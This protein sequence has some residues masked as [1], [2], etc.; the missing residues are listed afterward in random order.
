M[1]RDQDH[2]SQRASVRVR[3]ARRAKQISALLILG[4]L[5]AIGWIFWSLHREGR[6]DGRGGISSLLK[7]TRTVPRGGRYAGD[8]YI[9]S[10]TCGEC[11]PGEAALF[12]SSGH[13]RTMRMAAGFE[14]ADELAGRSADDPLLPGVRWT[15]QRKDDQFLVEREAEGAIRRFVIDYALGS[16]HHAVTFVTMLDLDEPRILEHRLTYYPK[17]RALRLTPG[18]DKGKDL[19]GATSDGVEY[20][21]AKARKCLGCHSTQLSNWGN[22]KLDP[23]T[24]IAAVTC[25]RCHG[26]GRAHVEATKHATPETDLSMPM[27]LGS[28]TVQSQFDL[29]GKCHR[30][31]A[32]VPPAQLVPDDPFLARFQPVGLSQSRCFKGSDGRLSCVTCHDPHARASSDPAHYE[33]ICM[34]CHR[35]TTDSPTSHDSNT[36]APPPASLCPVSPSSDCLPCHMPKIDSGQHVAFSDH[37][38]RVHRPRAER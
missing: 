27:G 32:R 19:P 18:H 17:D 37:W 11:H 36:P 15:F 25:E 35:A 10:A 4:A 23:P 21:G 22:A 29:C 28:W 30:H 31:P 14:L 2:Q 9:G 7:I 16:G 34:N 20:D 3:P 33:Q 8:P 12:K 5:A 26:P 1:T 38:I 24:L 6:F 13:A